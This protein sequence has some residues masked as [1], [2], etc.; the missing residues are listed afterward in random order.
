[1]FTLSVCMIVKNEER[2]LGRCLEGVS[3]VADELIVVDTG[4]EDR[5]AEI[6][7]QYTDRVYHHPW[8]NSFSEARNYASSLATCD[9]VMWIDADEVITDENVDG[10]RRLKSDMPEN[11][12]VVF[13]IERNDCGFFSDYILRDHIIRRCFADRF[14][15]NIHEAIHIDPAWKRLYARDICILHRKEYVNEPTRNLD[16]LERAGRRP[17]GMTDRELAYYSRELLVHGQPEKAV[18][19]YRELCGR[20]EDN[21]CRYHSLIFA[22]GAWMQME[23]YDV[24]AREIVRAFETV[25]PTAYMYCQLGLCY[26]KLGNADRAEKAYRSALRIPEHPETFCI[27]F[28]GYTDYFPALR[29]TGL[30]RR[31]GRYEEAA[32]WNALARRANPQG[33]EWKWDA[34]LLRGKTDGQP[35]I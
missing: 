2:V 8:Q 28:S 4:S 24:C 26:E 35:R 15:S 5:S 18:A 14:Q 3:K 30:C 27:Q 12:D 25:E 22:V 6:A 23:Q 32:W 29:M 33:L 1:M 16:Y 19:A 10:I 31:A 34:I 20:S 21:F 7:A 9:Y 11:I 13:V 17:G